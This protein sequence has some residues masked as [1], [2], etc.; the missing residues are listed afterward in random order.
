VARKRGPKKGHNLRPLVVVED[1]A[2]QP[3]E[4]NEPVE[5]GV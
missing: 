3:A 2:H 1:V 5:V 4:V